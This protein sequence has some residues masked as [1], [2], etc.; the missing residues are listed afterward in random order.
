M[1]DIANLAGRILLAALFVAGAGQKALDPGPVMGL[2]AG[3]GWPVWLVWPALAFNA[4]GAAALIL[5]VA[6]R[7]VA[8]ALAGYCMVTSIFHFIPS[9]DWQMTIFVK[10]WAIAGGFLVLA[11]SGPG[12]WA[13]GR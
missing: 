13:L 3:R 1:R 10:N 7:P 4:F 9:D 11:D 8:V 5:G 2:L 12:R 6:T